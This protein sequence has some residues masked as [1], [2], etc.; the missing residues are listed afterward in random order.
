MENVCA[1][2]PALPARAAGWAEAGGAAT[3]IQSV[4]AVNVRSAGGAGRR[5]RVPTPAS[6]PST[7]L[8]AVVMRS[9]GGTADLEFRVV[10]VSMRII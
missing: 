4:T 3:Q 8:E 7:L 2:G 5:G 10:V 1:S 6:R 9:K